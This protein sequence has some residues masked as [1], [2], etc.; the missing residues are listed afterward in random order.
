MSRSGP[1]AKMFFLSA[2]SDID[3]I[4]SALSNGAR[5]YVLNSDLGRELLA[6]M[7]EVFGGRFV[8]SGLKHLPTESPLFKVFRLLESLSA[9]KIG[10][11][12]VRPL[13]ASVHDLIAAGQD[14]GFEQEGVNRTV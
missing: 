13:G 8:S 2:C 3:V 12:R 11:E 14:Y 4:N 9:N 5:G 10:Q 6:A 1:S 7:R